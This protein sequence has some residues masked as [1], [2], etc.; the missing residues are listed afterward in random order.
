MRV[1][2]HMS[3]GDG[4]TVLVEHLPTIDAATRFFRARI[5]GDDAH[6]YGYVGGMEVYADVYPHSPKDTSM[7]AYGEWPLFRLAVGPRGGVVREAC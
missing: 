6:H 5:E 3:M 2:M 7:E 1:T 4:I